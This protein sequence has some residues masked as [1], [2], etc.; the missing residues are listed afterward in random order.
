MAMPLSIPLL[1]L[2]IRILGA[3]TFIHL[4]H[5]ISAYRA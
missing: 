2:I 1:N 3:T 5:R 4:Y